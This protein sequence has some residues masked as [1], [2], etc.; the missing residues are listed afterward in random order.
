MNT[1]RMAPKPP[2]SPL[3]FPPVLGNYT[4]AQ[5]EKIMK[6]VGKAAIRAALGKLVF[7]S[8]SRGD[9]YNE[10]PLQ[11][12]D[13]PNLPSFEDYVARVASSHLASLGSVTQQD[14]NDYFRHQIR[15]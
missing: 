1:L 3:P 6:K 5:D 10:D 13:D 11:F 4:D 9:V 7:D 8:A 15:G 2:P 12:D 14:L